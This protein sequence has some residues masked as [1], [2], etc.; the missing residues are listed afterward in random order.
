MVIRA[1]LIVALLTAAVFAIAFVGGDPFVA[2]IDSVPD[3]FNRST[4]D[5]Y[6]LRQSIWRATWDLIKDHPVAGSGFGGY[7]IAITKYHHASGEITPQQAANDYLELLAGGGV[8]GFAIAIWLAV[9]LGRVARS[10]LCRTSAYSRAA[11]LGAL[12]GILT[13]AV[14]SL[15]DF[16]LHITINAFVFAVLVSLLVIN[17]SEGVPPRRD[18]TLINPG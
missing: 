18:G 17:P 1:L 10:K 14:H 9:I 16:G 12:A 11:T 13:V 6:V 5:S 8:I 4:A 15:V 2:R 7:W 3:E